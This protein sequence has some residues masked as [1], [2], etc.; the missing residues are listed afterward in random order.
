MTKEV[1]H[2]VEVRDPFRWLEDVDSERTR[3]W[4]AE[5]QKESRAFLDALPEREGIE[6][7]LRELWN[8]QR[9][10]PP[11]VRG[12]RIFF[13]HNDGLANQPTIY[14]AAGLQGAPAVLLDP[15]QLASDGSISVSDWKPSPDGRFVAW[16]AAHAG[17]DWLEWRVRDVATGKDSPDLLRWC[18]FTTV[19]WLP[20]GSGIFYA[21]YP[22]PE[23]GSELTAINKRQRLYLHRLGTEQAADELILARDDHADWGFAGE[24]TDDGALCVITSSIGTDTRNRVFLKRLGSNAP[25][26]TVFGEF[27]ASYDFIGKAGDELL[28]RTDKD[29]PKGRVIAVRAGASEPAHWRSVVPESAATLADARLAGGHI[30]VLVMDAVKHRVH[31]HKISGEHI[32][33]VSFPA[34]GT[35]SGL[36]ARA[37]HNEIFL[38]FTS[39]TR[40]PSILR[41]E[42]STGRTSVWRESAVKSDLSRFVTE[43]VECTSR[44]GT[45]IPMY[46]VR[47]SDVLA[48][49]TAPALLYGYGGFN[50]PVLPGFSA[51]VLAWLE[52]GGIYAVPALRGGGEFGE[53]WHRAGM[54]EQKQ[55]VFDDFIA[56][57]EWLVRERWTTPS[58]LA[59]QGGSNGG[60]LVGACMTQR[61][62]L[63]GAAL[64]AVGVMDM[65]R[66]HR[67]TIGWAWVSEYGSAD[68]ATQFPTL[69]AYSPLHQLKEGVRYPATLVITADH[70]DRVVPAHSFKF[71]ARLQEVQAADG[72]P[73]L[74][75]IESK[76][77]HG[78]GTPTSKAIEEAA[79][80][81]AFLRQVLTAVPEAR[82]GN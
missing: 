3:A 77:G 31:I 18:K 35:V 6:T 14:S 16:A 53:A 20:D 15:A 39:F 36:T 10:S 1:L 43:Q 71:A 50:I 5:R 4:V 51:A 67:F 38:G 81:I 72:P 73:C 65:L 58:R 7:R 22:E 68:D 34:M 64:P 49:S 63:F 74:I 78:A 26:E 46:V 59:I 41:H 82:R 17:S 52:M 42:V 9:W 8:Y 19:S 2:G 25:V 23:A 24:V 79:D 11:V 66:Y 69:L 54:L 12:T 80:R 48:N 45:R 13:A 62:E 56:A 61:P 40:P 28:F 27:D 70:D 47:R 55:N 76:A 21:R 60:L 57:A 30:A 37:S 33:E 75:R 29:A 44:D 32:H